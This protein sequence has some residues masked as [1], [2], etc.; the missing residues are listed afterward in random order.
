MFAKCLDLSTQVQRSYAKTPLFCI[1]IPARFGVG[2]GM[3]TTCRDAI[4]GTADEQ[5]W[6]LMDGWV[7]VKSTLVRWVDR[8]ALAYRHALGTFWK[9]EFLACKMFMF[10]SDFSTKYLLSA[11]HQWFCC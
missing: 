4:A 9:W 3:E 8:E 2:G 6:D 1:K 11:F 10:S 5:G 7:M